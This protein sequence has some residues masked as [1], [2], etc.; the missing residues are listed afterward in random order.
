MRDYKE[1]LLIDGYCVIPNVLSLEEV[2]YIRNKFLDFF[3]EEKLT[4]TTNEVLNNNILSDILFSPKVIETLNSI[5]GDG[6]CMYPDFTLRSS[7]YVPWHTDVPYL[8]SEEAHNSNQADF[9]QVSIYLQDN[10]E[11]GGGGLDIIPG[12]H[13]NKNIQYNNFNTK[14]VDTTKHIKMP[15]LAGSVALWDSRIVHRSSL[16]IDN[17]T[18][19][20]LALQWTIS[21]TD[22]YSD[23]YLSFIAIRITAKQKDPVYDKTNREMEHLLSMAKLSCPDSFNAYQRKII[24]DYDIQLKLFNSDINNVL[25]KA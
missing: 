6:Y 3:S 24:N 16:S 22:K 2:R 13:T 8:S 1:E 23:K 11:T 4:L 19:T 25:M 15:S 21:R 7:V 18:I 14:N 5:V 20:K 17:N 9:I 10:T 12:S